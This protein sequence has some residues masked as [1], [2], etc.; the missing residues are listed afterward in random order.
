MYKLRVP[1]LA[2]QDQA[3][4]IIV[5]NIPYQMQVSVPATNE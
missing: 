3:I 1:G 2:E 5:E 4:L